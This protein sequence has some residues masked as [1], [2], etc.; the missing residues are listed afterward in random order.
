MEKSG[1]RDTAGATAGAKKCV[2]EIH[3]GSGVFQLYSFDI[4]NRQWCPGISSVEIYIHT[5][6]LFFLISKSWIQ[7]SVLPDHWRGP[8][9]TVD[10]SHKYPWPEAWRLQESGCENNRLVCTKHHVVMFFW[11]LIW[12]CLFQSSYKVSDYANDFHCLQI[13]TTVFIVQTWSQFIFYYELGFLHDD[14]FLV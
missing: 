5:H 6:T 8:N 13:W 12:Q 4:Y 2:G 10:S 7:G 3:R 11:E 9:T 14:L 1:T